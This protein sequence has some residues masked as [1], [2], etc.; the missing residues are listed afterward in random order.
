[1]AIQIL[2][3]V[4][5]NINVWNYSKE[6]AIPKP[7]RANLVGY[8]VFGFYFFIVKEEKEWV[9]SEWTTG[10]RVVWGTNKKEVLK[11]LPEKAAEVGEGKFRAEVIRK[12]KE[13]GIVNK[14]KKAL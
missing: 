2:K 8:T 4:S 1:M 13:F 5:V 10:N 6:K 9:I 3:E 7:V 14:P 11:S 12:Q